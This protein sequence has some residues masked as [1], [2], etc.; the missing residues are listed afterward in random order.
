MIHI[1]TMKLSVGDIRIFHAC[2]VTSSGLTALAYMESFTSPIEGEILRKG[3]LTEDVYPLFESS[4]LLGGIVGTSIAGPFCEWIGVK[5]ALILSSPLALLGSAL[6]V[7]AHDPASMIVSRFLIG[8]FSGLSASCIPVYNAEI[9]TTQMKAFYGSILGVSLRIGPLLSYVLGVWFGFRYLTIIYAF[10]ITIMILNIC[11]IPDSPGWLYRNGLEREAE[12]ASRYFQL[13]TQEQLPEVNNALENVGT[14]TSTKLFLKDKIKGYFVWSIIRPVLICVSI[15][16]FKTS[17]GNELL[18]TSASHTLEA[19]LKMDPN[20]AST[21]YSVFVLLGSVSFLWIIRKVHW[22]KLILFTTSIQLISNA[23]LA[24]TFYLSIDIYRCSDNQ[25]STLICDI[26]QFA[27]LLLVSSFAFAMALGCGSIGYY[28]I[29]EILHHHYTRISS[30]IVLFSAYT[31]SYLN[32][33]VAPY[34][35]D[36]LGAPAVF[37]GYAIVC[38]VCVF[39]QCLY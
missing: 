36:H 33:L 28:L 39:I 9:S 29:G 22:K 27:P 38:L 10:I 30:G 19:G 37:M 25:Q 35:V 17:S 16:V 15:H 26:L 34:L 14:D 2:M 5:S 11:L 3:I 24:T 1:R 32:I 31:S 12:R 8:F 13:D 20:K 4:L 21:L 18:L 7:W 23:L 6:L